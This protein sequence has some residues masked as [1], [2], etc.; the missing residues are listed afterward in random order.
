ME[1]SDRA[2]LSIL[3]W[4]DGF[5]H[6][7]RVESLVLAA[8]MDPYDAGQMARRPTPKIVQMFDAALRDEVLGVLHERG[9]MALAPTRSQMACH[10]APESPGF[11]TRFSGS[12]P[13]GFA[14]HT[15]D[16]GAW[17]FRPEDV[18]LVVAGKV[19]RVGRVTRH[20]SPFDPGYA[21]DRS[22]RVSSQA[23][24]LA[25]RADAAMD[26]PAGWGMNTS[27]NTRAVET[28]DLHMVVDGRGRVVRL[29]GGSARIR[30]DTEPDRR[31]SLIDAH[32]P[33]DDLKGWIP[34]AVFD[35]WFP[36]FNTPGDVEAVAARA[37]QSSSRL[38][39]VAFDFYSV[40]VAMLDRAVRGW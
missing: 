38:N 1:P 21:V 22:D 31:P 3:S 26:E 20:A 18:R 25:I 29:A 15:R 37:G 14:V 11:V 40:W 7:D 12:P 28:I 8:G 17:T 9:V 5:M 33:V 36:N 19:R 24:D 35:E 16:G 30:L 13:R 34:D 6:A 39:P 10:P 23:L 2:Y 4:P 32:R 27:R